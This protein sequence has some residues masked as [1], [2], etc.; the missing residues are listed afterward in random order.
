[1]SASFPTWENHGLE[2]FGL[3]WVKL[4]WVRL[5]WIGL[6]NLLQLELTIL[7]LYLIPIH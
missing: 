7:V 3:S 5:N 1:M 6:G 4:G 2:N